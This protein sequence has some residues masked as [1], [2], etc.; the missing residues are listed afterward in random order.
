MR[1]IILFAV[2]LT[3]ISRLSAQSFNT[4]DQDRNSKVQS[5]FPN[6]FTRE[7]NF[8]YN[9]TLNI[10]Y[11][12]IKV[13]NILGTEIYKKDVKISKG[14]NSVSIDFDITLQAGVYFLSINDGKSNSFY[15]LRKE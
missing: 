12:S 8:T 14:S 1:K 9:N 11:L 6:P 13:L 3:S 7:I 2:L 4:L 10:E 5:I 15:K